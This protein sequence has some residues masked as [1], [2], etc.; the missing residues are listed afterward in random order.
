MDVDLLLQEAI[1]TIAQS[2]PIIKLLQQVRMGKMKPE[3]PGL[4]AVIEAWLGTYEKVLKTKGLTHA[5]LRRL[6]PAPRIGLLLDAGVLR[7]DQASVRGLEGTFAQALA[8][9]PIA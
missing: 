1:G 7:A 4:R 5:A 8:H 9:A 6:D 3:D 2:D